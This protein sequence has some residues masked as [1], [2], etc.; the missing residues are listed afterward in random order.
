MWFM[1]EGLDEKTG[2][3][4]SMAVEAGGKAEAEFIARSRGVDVVSVVFDKAGSMPAPEKPD[5]REVPVA[6][7]A[8]LLEFEIRQRRLEEMGIP[9]YEEIARGE[10]DGSCGVGMRCGG[11]VAGGFAVFLWFASAYD[12]TAMEGRLGAIILAT[13]LAALLA[14]AAAALKMGAV[15]GIA[16]RDL[17]RH[18]MGVWVERKEPDAV[19]SG[20]PMGTSTPH[21]REG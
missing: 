15:M 10:V 11:G 6:S 8:G 3:S 1:V 18:Q 17:M 20:V 4:M 2:R 16:R 7:V 12:R 5:L 19:A 13:G 21:D 14:G 9:A